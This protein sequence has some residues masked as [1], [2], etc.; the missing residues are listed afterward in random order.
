MPKNQLYFLK[1][2][3]LSWE[4]TRVNKAYT[5]YKFTLTY[6][7]LRV[8]DMRLSIFCLLAISV[9]CFVGCGSKKKEVQVSGKITYNG[10]PIDTGVIQFEPTDKN[11]FEGGGNIED[12]K[13]T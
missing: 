6:F 5:G 9:F 11:G 10:T 8:T 13:Y 3:G 1:T 7:T 12:G 2:A 4:V